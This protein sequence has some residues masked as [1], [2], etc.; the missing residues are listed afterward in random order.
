LPEA[1]LSRVL[2]L[3]AGGAGAAIAHAVADLG[4]ETLWIADQDPARA[5]ALAQAVGRR[6]PDRR[7]SACHDVHAAMQAASGLIHATPTGMEK[8]PGIP[9]DPGWLHP[10]LWVSEVV[11]FPLETALLRAAKAAGC[12]VVDGGGMAVGQALG[13]FELFT[14]LKANEERML[15]HFRQL[16]DER[17]Q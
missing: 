9:V 3:G 6:F 10:G 12:A 8:L 5:A 14:G 1:D 13:A 4:V 15:A 16:L 11:Y 17:G 7:V 2:L